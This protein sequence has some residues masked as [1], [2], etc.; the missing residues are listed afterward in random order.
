MEAERFA[1]SLTLETSPHHGIYL[2]TF[3]QNFPQHHMANQPPQLLHLQEQANLLHMQQA[4]LE[5]Q[6]HELQAAVERG[7]GEARSNDFG[8]KNY[9]NNPHP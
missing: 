2:H 4:E 7:I 5:R 6:R 9:R 1:D 3:P 8:E